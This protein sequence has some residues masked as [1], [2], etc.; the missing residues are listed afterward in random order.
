MSMRGN[1][2]RRIPKVSK[3]ELERLRAER[4]AAVD[5]RRAIEQDRRIETEVMVLDVTAEEVEDE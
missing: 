3:Q 5:R 1:I 2:Q 4:R